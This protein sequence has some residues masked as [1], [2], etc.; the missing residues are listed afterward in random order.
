MDTADRDSNADF[1]LIGRGASP[2]KLPRPS[3]NILSQTP[4]SQMAATYNLLVW[5]FI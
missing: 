3:T 2:I 1:S 4:K 5:N